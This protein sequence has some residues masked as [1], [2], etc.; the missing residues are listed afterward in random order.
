MSFFKKRISAHELGDVIYAHIR[1]EVMSPD[2]PLFHAKLISQLEEN[3]D[4]LPPAYI[5]ELLIGSLFGALLS[6]EKKHPYPKAGIIIDTIRNTFISHAQP[7]MQ[8]LAITDE[9][10]TTLIIQRFHEYHESLDITGAGPGWHLG[11][12]Y[13]WNILGRKKEDPKGP[14]YSSLYILKFAD[15][16]DGILK[17]Y[18]V[19]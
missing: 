4:G 2:S 6:I 1:Y 11:K 5:L 7:I 13:Y 19:L 17:G 16:A 15:F 3:P 9:E 18:K 8:N 14:T 10:M 12:A